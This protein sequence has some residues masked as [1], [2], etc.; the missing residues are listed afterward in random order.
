LLLICESCLGRERVLMALLKEDLGIIE[1][2]LRS[3][4]ASG[5]RNASGDIDTA[6]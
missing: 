4:P 2:S 3:E 6:M 1:P 5:Y